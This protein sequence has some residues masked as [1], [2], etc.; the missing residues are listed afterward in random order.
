MDATINA[1]GDLLL[2]AIPTIL[3][4]IFL[5][6]YLQRV[7]FRPMARIFEQRRKATEGL[8]EL[9]QRAFEEVDEK[10]SAYERALQAA[11]AEISAENEKV[12]RQ[13]LQEQ[14]DTV[15]R[16][17]GEAEGKL[18]AER[19]VIAGEVA[20]ADTDIQAQIQPLTDQIIASLLRRR[21]A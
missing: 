4:F 16:A 14:A 15:A 9:S 20:K 3:F 8:R 10:T 11:R 1:I 19:A 21:A 6:F 17:R 7:Y 18:A 12:R 2:K 13:W 5:T